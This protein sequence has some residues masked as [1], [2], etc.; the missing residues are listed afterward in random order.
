MSC[1]QCLLVP[2]SHTEESWTSLC[3]TRVMKY[4]SLPPHALSKTW[5]NGSCIPHLTVKNDSHHAQ[6]K[7]K[8]FSHHFNGDFL[9]PVFGQLLQSWT[10]LKVDDTSLAKARSKSDALSRHFN[11]IYTL[12][13]SNMMTLTGATTVNRKLSSTYFCFEDDFNWKSST[14]NNVQTI[15]HELQHLNRNSIPATKRNATRQF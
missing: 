4:A 2:S 6:P 13:A 14:K 8:W 7:N 9:F 3:S 10:Y 15:I 11:D 1:K 5:G 12:E